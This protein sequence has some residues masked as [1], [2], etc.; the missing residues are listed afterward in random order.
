MNASTSAPLTGCSA[1]ALH[2][3]GRVSAAAPER[4]DLTADW[5][6]IAT[7]L[8][9]FFKALPSPCSPSATAPPGRAH[10]AMDARRSR[11]GSKDKLLAEGEQAD[12]LLQRAERCLVLL[13]EWLKQPMFNARHVSRR[14]VWRA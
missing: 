4:L 1:A 11:A 2:A 13:P 5:W 3:G 8:S 9:A 7:L 14:C 12:F 6:L 10:L